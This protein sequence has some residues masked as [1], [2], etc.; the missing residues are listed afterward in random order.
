MLLP[1]VFRCHSKITDILVG[2]F[3]YDSFDVLVFM[4]TDCGLRHYL[5][6]RGRLQLFALTDSNQKIELVPTPA[7]LDLE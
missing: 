6:R 1:P 2:H 4:H 7:T 3:G 5:V